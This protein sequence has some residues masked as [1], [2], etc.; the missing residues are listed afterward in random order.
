MPVLKERQGYNGVKRNFPVCVLKHLFCML[1]QY[2]QQAGSSAVMYLL[3]NNSLWELCVDS[4]DAV[5]LLL[6]FFSF[7]LFVPFFIIIIPRLRIIWDT[8]DVCTC[9][10]ADVRFRH[11]PFFTL[12]LCSERIHFLWE[13]ILTHIA[14]I[15]ISFLVLWELLLVMVMMIVVVAVV[16][17]KRESKASGQRRPRVSLLGCDVR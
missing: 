10:V 12:L 7:F 8:V 2:G 3:Y 13:N 17:G 5:W 4:K 6:L 14:C 1:I 9:G 16:K 15:I 11:T